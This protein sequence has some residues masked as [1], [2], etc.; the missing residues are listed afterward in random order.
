MVSF[1]P[2]P[3]YSREYSSE[4]PS[5]R[6][7]GG[8]ESLLDIGVLTFSHL[9]GTAAPSLT[10]DQCTDWVDCFSM[11]YIHMDN[12]YASKCE[13]FILHLVLVAAAVRWLMYILG[14][15]EIRFFWGVEGE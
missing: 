5:D 1:M 4:Y 10:L 15:K 9:N 8:P 11:K 12:D 14:V 6:R 3:H 13:I 2:C 7:L